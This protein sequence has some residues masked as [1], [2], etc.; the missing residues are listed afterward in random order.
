MQYHV[1]PPR[2]RLAMPIHT[3]TMDLNRIRN[4]GYLSAT[5]APYELG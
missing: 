3:T 1:F 2:E 4:S 5:P